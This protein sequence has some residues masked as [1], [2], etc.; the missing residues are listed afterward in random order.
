MSTGQEYEIFV[1]NLQQALIDSEDYLRHKNI[2][3]ERNKKIEDNFGIVR[4]FDLYW[5]YELGGIKYKTIIECKDY[6]SRI[7]VEKIDALIGKIRDIPDLKPI[8]AT[9]TGYQSGA[10]QKAK[11]NKID[12]LIVREQKE[13]DW[14]DKDGNPLLKIINVKVEAQL[15]VRITAFHPIIDGKWVQ[16]NTGIDISKPLIVEHLSN[17]IFIHD[18]LKQDHFSVYELENRLREEYREL[19]GLQN[20][21]YDYNDAYI[22]TPDYKFKLLALNIEFYVQKPLS[23][24]FTIDFSKEL[25]G[26]IEYLHKDQKTAIFREKI[27]ENW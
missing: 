24:P 13:N 4:E 19:Y 10:E 23:M 22:E 5:E 14:T 27:V 12:L 3:I 6:C 26:V 25:L 2:K 17:E 1:Q 11:N 21:R 18:Q 16:E 7:S 20:I 9:K 15:P 8:F